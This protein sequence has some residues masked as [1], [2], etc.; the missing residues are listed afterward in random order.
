MTVEGGPKRQRVGV[1]D[2]AGGPATQ[3]RVRHG[4]A[5]GFGARRR[6][7]RRSA[8]RRVGV[9]GRRSAGRRAASI[10]TRSRS[11]SSRSP[12]RR[13][14]ASGSRASD[15]SS[16][17]GAVTPERTPGLRDAGTGPRSTRRPRAGA[18]PPTSGRRPGITRADRRV[19]SNLHVEQGRAL[20]RSTSR[21]RSPRRSRRTAVG[22]SR[23]AVKAN[24]ARHHRNGRPSRSRCCRSPA[25]CIAVHASARTHSGTSVATFGSSS[26]VIP[27][28]TNAI[29]SQVERVARRAAED[30]T[31]LGRPSSR[32]STPTS[33]RRLGRPPG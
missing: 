20:D 31:T 30:E 18:T 14:L 4:I 33:T 32:P 6:C 9:R 16:S 23:S 5:P 10:P 29:A 17:T 27:G 19:S 13:A 11:P 12:T 24:H 1:V 22:S 26:R 25:R 21:S 2:A 7:V 15:R 28:G 8:R 3:R